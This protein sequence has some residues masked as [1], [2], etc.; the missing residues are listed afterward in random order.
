MLRRSKLAV[1]RFM[2]FSR[3]S[4]MPCQSQQ[5]NEFCAKLNAV[6]VLEGVKRH[7]AQVCAIDV[8]AVRDDA[9]L[10]E[11]GID[12]VRA[13]DLLVALEDEFSIEIPDKDVP[14]LQTV[15]ELV[16]YVERKTSK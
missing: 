13:M 1:Q 14:R 6:S 16:A 12:S 5:E 9:R 8:S 2:R 11:F 10:A 7:V 15:R 4:G 3:L